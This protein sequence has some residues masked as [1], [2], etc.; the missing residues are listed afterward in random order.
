MPYQWRC[1]IVPERTKEP[2]PGVGVGV[3]AGVGVGVGAGV[4]VVVAGAIDG[5][6]AE[7]GVGVD[8]EPS[9]PA[10][11]AMSSTVVRMRAQRAD[12]RVSLLT[13][14]PL[15]ADRSRGV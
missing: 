9:Q 6:T 7:D 2:I 3:G 8:P 11:A 15:Q 12:E 14:I 10:T 4:G 5:V 1:S 13:W